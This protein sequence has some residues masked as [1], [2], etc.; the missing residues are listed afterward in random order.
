M[1]NEEFKEK[2][3]NAFIQ[4]MKNAKDLFYIEEYTYTPSWSD[5]EQTRMKEHMPTPGQALEMLKAVGVSRV[6]LRFYGG[7]DSG[8]VE[9][10][11]V[12]IDDPGITFQYDELFGDHDIGYRKEDHE[13]EHSFTRSVIRLKD[14]LADPIWSKYGSFAGDF[15]VSGNLVYD[16]VKSTVELSGEESSWESFATIN[17]LDPNFDEQGMRHWG[18]KFAEGLIG[19]RGSIANKAEE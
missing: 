19:I 16:C 1:T 7:H 4:V 9:E 3:Q 13:R 8:D 6:N 14:A 11:T 15:S 17:C 12:E 10:V 18:E 2:L 5:K